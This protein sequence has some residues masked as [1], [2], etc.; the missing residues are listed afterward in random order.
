MSFERY[1]LY[2]LVV[3]GLCIAIIWVYLEDNF[4]FEKNR[5]IIKKEKG[6]NNE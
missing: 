3:G 6:V 2:H 5:E 4:L 1:W